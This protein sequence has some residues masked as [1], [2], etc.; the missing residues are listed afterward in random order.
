MVVI[1]PAIFAQQ[2]PQLYGAALQGDGHR[3]DQVLHGGTGGQFRQQFGGAEKVPGVVEFPIFGQGGLADEGIG[4]AALFQMPVL[5]HKGR[6]VFS[7]PAVLVD[8]GRIC[9]DVAEDHTDAPGRG[10]DFFA[11]FFTV[12]DEGPLFP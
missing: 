4:Q 7:H 11:V 2:D 6:I 5:G 10:D 3:L 9:G 1:R 12:G 8:F